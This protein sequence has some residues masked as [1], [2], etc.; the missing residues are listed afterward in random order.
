MIHTYKA[1]LRGTSPLKSSLPMGLKL[2]KERTRKD[3]LRKRA[4]KVMPPVHLRR[5]M[6]LISVEV[7]DSS[8]RGPRRE[9]ERRDPSSTRRKGKSNEALPLH[10]SAAHSM[11][12]LAAPRSAGETK[13]NQG[14]EGGEESDGKENDEEEDGALDQILRGNLSV[15][16]ARELLGLPVRADHGSRGRGDR[17]STPHLSRLCCGDSTAKEDLPPLLSMEEQISLLEEARKAGAEEVGAVGS[18]T[19]RKHALALLTWAVEAATVW[20]ARALRRQRPPP[21]EPMHAQ[22]EE[23]EGRGGTTPSKA[24]QPCAS[25][26][27]FLTLSTPTSLIPTAKL[28]KLVRV[29]PG[30]VHHADRTFLAA[31]S[32]P[33]S[34]FCPLETLL[35][36]VQSLWAAYKAWCVR[37]A[38]LASLKKATRTKA[39][40]KVPWRLLE[41]GME[42][43]MEDGVEAGE[44]FALLDVPGRAGMIALRQEAETWLR[45]GRRCWGRSKPDDVIS[46]RSWKDAEDRKSVV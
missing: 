46:L 39:L 25:L 41:A 20:R 8:G 1:V 42:G 23:K 27:P 2:E 31:A 32:P 9:E 4:E 21:L 10:R 37:A 11:P 30:L 36:S 43:E 7:P 16:D 26:P 22:G 34:S 24:P 14:G 3:G 6:A 28:D 44:V 12:L 13:T 45:M 38:P 40:A 5:A 18:A 33:S 15:S 35:S 29:G 19:R 17:S